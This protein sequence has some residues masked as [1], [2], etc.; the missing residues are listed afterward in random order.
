MLKIAICEDELYMTEQLKE[1]VN[2]YINTL[3]IS[4]CFSTFAN[5]ED[6]LESDINFD[7]I[8]MDIKLKGIDGM[9][10]V[11]QL[12]EK[13]AECQIIFTTAYKEY[14]FKAFDVDAIHY[15]IKPVGEKDLFHAIDKALRRFKQGNNNELITIKKGNLIQ[16]IC[17]NEIIY[18]E[19]MNHKI[20][21]HTIKEDVD[22][23]GTL[24]ELEK[25]LDNRF[26]RC[27]RSYIVNMNYVVNKEKETAILTNGDKILISRRKHK[28]F[29]EKLLKFFQDEVL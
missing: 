10:T 11:K 19:V 25:Q 3:H 15:L 21:I 18:C 23:F 5:G 8:F 29:K 7:I 24:D 27:H 28:E 13:G 16:I 1:K 20:N 4:V 17:L 12:R 14:V 22:Y 9:E 26:Y 6:L 2:T